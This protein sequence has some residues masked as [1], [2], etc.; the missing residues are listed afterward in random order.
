M[1][2]EKA[3]VLPE[4]VLYGCWSIDMRWYVENTFVI[5]ALSFLLY[6]VKGMFSTT[7]R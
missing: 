2:K 4:I 6:Q 7:L 3:N 1:L 5:I